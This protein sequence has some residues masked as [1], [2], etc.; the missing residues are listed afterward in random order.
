LKSKAVA[1]GCSSY[2]L[3]G[4]QI[5]LRGSSGV[6]SSG[7][8]QNPHGKIELDFNLNKSASSTNYYV[9]FIDSTGLTSENAV[10]YAEPARLTA[11]CIN[12]SRDFPVT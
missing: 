4:V 9:A 1:P 12:I 5:A 6:P 2:H 8:Q 10:V 3:A 11:F 7:Y